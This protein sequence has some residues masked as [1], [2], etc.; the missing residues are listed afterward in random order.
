MVRPSPLG[1][2]GLAGEPALA[3][4]KHR[5][6]TIAPGAIVLETFDP[7]DLRSVAL[8]LQAFMDRCDQILAA[9]KG[10][11][12]L[13]PYERAAV[14]ALYRSLKDDIRAE[15][16]R[17]ARRRTQH[18]SAEV[19]FLRDAVRRALIELRPQPNWDPISSGWLLAVTEAEDELSTALKSV[20]QQAQSQWRGRG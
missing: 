14:A 3:N 12:Q 4:P 11:S 8:A 16:E 17:L 9:I 18:T 15:K 20:E 2:L 6:A 7:D 13:R 19:R 5:V 10:K 1:S